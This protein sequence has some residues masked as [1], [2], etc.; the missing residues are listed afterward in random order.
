[1]YPKV[2]I[3][4]KRSPFV[5]NQKAIE[6]KPKKKGGYVVPCRRVALLYKDGMVFA[7]P[8]QSRKD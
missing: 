3:P 5:S 2:N 1:M 4:Q 7:W 8:F 6:L